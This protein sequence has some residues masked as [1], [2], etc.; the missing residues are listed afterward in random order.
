MNYKDIPISVCMASFNGERFI[1]IQIESIVN[2]FTTP[3]DELIIV[4]DCS[5][6][7]TVK[8]IEDLNS[9]KIRLLKIS[10]I[11]AL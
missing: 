5:T 8:I 3:L 1:K 2:Q 4:D 9:Q 11:K 10:Q 7:S 6:D